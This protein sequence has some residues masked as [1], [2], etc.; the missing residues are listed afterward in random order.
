MPTCCAIVPYTSLLLR[1]L[2]DAPTFSGFVRS[3]FE[4]ARAAGAFCF[5]F[6]A[7]LTPPIVLV[8][9]RH[10]IGRGEQKGNSDTRFF[11]EKSAIRGA[12][13]ACRWSS[14]TRSLPAAPG[15]ARRP[16]GHGLCDGT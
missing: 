14:V 12:P 15:P 9:A 7:I 16:S 2:E 6:V 5:A 1:A 11:P 3:S 13:P 8:T 4:T 10:P